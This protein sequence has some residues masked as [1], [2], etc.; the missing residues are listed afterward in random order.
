M[1]WLQRSALR[2]LARAL[3]SREFGFGKDTWG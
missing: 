3:G 2:S 1:R